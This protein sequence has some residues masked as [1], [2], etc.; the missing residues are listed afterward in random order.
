MRG[1]TMIKTLE[2][3]DPKHLDDTTGGGVIDTVTKTAKKVTDA[4]TGTVFPRPNGPQRPCIVC[5]R[6]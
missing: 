3:I 6:G 1:E 5:G 2:T 4:I